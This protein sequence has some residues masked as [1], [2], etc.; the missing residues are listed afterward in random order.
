M[1]ILSQELLLKYQKGEFSKLC[2]VVLGELFQ[3]W[4][5]SRPNTVPLTDRF[6]K[7]NRAKIRLSQ[8]SY[9]LRVDINDRTHT[10]IMMMMIIIIITIIIII[11]I[12]IIPTVFI[13]LY[14]GINQ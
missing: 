13:L 14:T 7:R 1:E 12:I 4:P 2:A 6:L 9:Y 8:L 11:I 10:V 5:R 3:I